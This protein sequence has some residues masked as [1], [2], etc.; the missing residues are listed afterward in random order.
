[1]S[2]DVCR[3]VGEISLSYVGAPSEVFSDGEYPLS[4]VS[5]GT[6]LRAPPD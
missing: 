1:M 5:A 2:L 6:G 3:R 4:D